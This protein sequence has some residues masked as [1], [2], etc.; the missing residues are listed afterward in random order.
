MTKL[1]RVK[2]VKYLDDHEDEFT[3]INLENITT[4]CICDSQVAHLDKYYLLR[5][6]SETD[7][8]CLDKKFFDKE[9][10]GKGLLEIGK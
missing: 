9:V 3:Y 10:I 5:F 8:E 6:G 7:T 2:L 4:L 1:T